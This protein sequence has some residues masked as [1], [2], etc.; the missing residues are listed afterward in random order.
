MEEG[1]LIPC[2]SRIGLHTD[3]VDRGM[4]MRGCDEKKSVC[5]A[6]KR[7]TALISCLLEVSLGTRV[8]SVGPKNGRT[9]LDISDGQDALE[10]S[11]MLVTVS[12]WRGGPGDRR[13]PELMLCETNAAST[14]SLQGRGWSIGSGES[15]CL[16]GLC[17]H[18]V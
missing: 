2:F 11:E 16:L 10:L 13:P 17:S 12:T 8:A 6:L 9:I 7:P 15:V 18:P 1:R 5:S 4:D 3:A 14:S